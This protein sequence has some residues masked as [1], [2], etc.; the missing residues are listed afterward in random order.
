MRKYLLLLAAAAMVVMAAPSQA[1]YYATF[2]PVVVDTP[3]AN[4]NFKADVGETFSTANVGAPRLTTSGTFN[5]FFGDGGPGDPEL[6]NADLALYGFELLGSVSAVNDNVVDYTG[7]YAFRY[8][9]PSNTIYDVSQGSFA[10]QAIFDANGVASF[11]GSLNQLVGPPAGGPW[12]DFASFGP[13]TIS[14]IYRPTVPGQQ[15]IISGAINGSSAIP[16][17]GSLA[18]LA[19]G[20]LPLLGLRRR[21]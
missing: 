1:G 19:M 20:A 8:F 13:V 7:S 10:I 16:E 5:S 6:N 11:S 18:L 12:V 9:D 14:G 17:P 2:G 3:D 4:G 15:G 21:K